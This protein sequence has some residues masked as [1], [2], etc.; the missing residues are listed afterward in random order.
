LPGNSPAYR[1]KNVK[2]FQCGLT[3]VVPARP[4]GGCTPRTVIQIRKFA[5]RCG[6]V[7]EMM[8]S[9]VPLASCHWQSCKLRLN[10]LKLGLT[11]TPGSI[12]SNLKERRQPG[13]RHHIIGL[14]S[15]NDYVADAGHCSC[16]SLFLAVFR[17]SAAV[18]ARCFSLLFWPRG[19]QNSSVSAAERGRPL[20]FSSIISD[21]S[22]QQ[23]R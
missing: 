16:R 4:W 14:A 11:A 2:A 10:N 13:A 22:E 6:S 21:N 20:Y 17:C 15:P 18:I 7:A 9:G 5:P 1:Q 3:R 12:E 19:H 8:P 23:Y